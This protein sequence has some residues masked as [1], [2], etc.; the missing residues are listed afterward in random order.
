MTDDIVHEIASLPKNS[1]ETLK[2]SLQTFKG[3]R[4]LAARV[5]ATGESG[6]TP[7]KKG[8]NVRVE[9]GKPFLEALTRALAKARDLGWIEGGSP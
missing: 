5:W 8:I 9:Q 3:Q 7:T 1:R 2:V 6:E 4:L